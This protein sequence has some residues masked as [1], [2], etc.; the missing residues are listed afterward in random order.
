MATVVTTQVGPDGVLNL[1][2]PLGAAD[3][4]RKVRV[5][6]E[7]VDDS[8]GNTAVAPDREAWLR[9][10]AQTAGSIPDPTFD[11]QPQGQFEERDSL[12]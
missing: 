2:L 11:R 4:N 1:S 5:T 10:I 6:V 12:Q 7:P 3:A 9:F 8:I